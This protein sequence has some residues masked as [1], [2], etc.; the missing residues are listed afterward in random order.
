[1]SSSSSSS[2]SSSGSSRATPRRPRQ[3]RPARRSRSATGRSRT[4]CP[5]DEIEHVGAAGNYV[6]I[7]WR[8]ERLL[9]RATLL[10][11]EA[12]LG[13]AF[14]RIHRSRLVRK[15]AVRRVV[16]HKSGDFDV[17]MDSGDTLRGSRR[18]RGN[19]EG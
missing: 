5:I 17:E 12:D 13:P 18:Y 15:G 3:H 19:L 7:A 10:G 14:A 6:E 2:S 11:I 8:G 9:H 16:T 4:T 1:M